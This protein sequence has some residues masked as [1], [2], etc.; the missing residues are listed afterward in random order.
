MHKICKKD[1]YML[2]INHGSVNY[3]EQKK[4]MDYTIGFIIHVIILTCSD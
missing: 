3:R 1:V 4:P 2:R